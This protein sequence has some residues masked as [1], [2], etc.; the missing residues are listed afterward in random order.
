MVI[1]PFGLL[2]L[3]CLCVGIVGLNDNLGKADVALVLGNKV[4]PNGQPSPS[5]RARLDRAVDCYK[6]GW[7]PMVVVSGGL[8]K[9][10]FDEAVVMRD[11]MISK[12][13]PQAHIIADSQ[14]WTTLR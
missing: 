5:L 13:V 1:I 10:G 4:D 11:Y 9:E 14:G 12:G 6:Q 7:F 8:G 3:A 2:V